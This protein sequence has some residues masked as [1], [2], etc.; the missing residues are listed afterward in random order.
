[1]AMAFFISRF[2][3]GQRLFLLLENIKMSLIADRF[4]S[5]SFVMGY[6]WRSEVRLEKFSTEVGDRWLVSGGRWLVVEE[7][8]VFCGLQKKFVLDETFSQM[9]R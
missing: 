4:S 5:L 3:N 7:E 8:L 9:L 2:H 6:G 1:M